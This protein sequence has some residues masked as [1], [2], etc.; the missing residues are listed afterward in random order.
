MTKAAKEVWEILQS[1]FGWDT[2]PEGMQLEFMEDV[3][4][5]AK[6][7]IA[8]QKPRTVFCII[9]TNNYYREPVTIRVF[10]SKEKAEEFCR[11]KP[12]EKYH[13]EEEEVE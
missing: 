4:S 5:A 13:W 7:A 3:I 9:D 1:D 6:M 2:A 12:K 8:K 10:D 11:A